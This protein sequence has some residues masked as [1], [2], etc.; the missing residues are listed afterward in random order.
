MI[1]L[2]PRSTRTDTLFPYTTL[3]RSVLAR[4]EPGLAAAIGDHASRSPVAVALAGIEDAANL[5]AA[6][7]D[8]DQ[9]VVDAGRLGEGEDRAVDTLLRLQDLLPDFHFR[10]VIRCNEGAHR[11]AVEGVVARR[12]L[13]AVAQL[14]E[15]ALPDLGEL[16]V[17]LGAE[18]GRA[19]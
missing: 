7:G 1:R 18:I 17:V 3:F 9:R 19:H 15:G 12:G 11:D 5:D 8:G 13:V 6:L 4:G 10:R 2:P 16:D 14:A